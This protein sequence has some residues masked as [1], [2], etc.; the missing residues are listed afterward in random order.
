MSQY[1]SKSEFDL[2]KRVHLTNEIP[3]FDM[4]DAVNSVLQDNNLWKW[5]LGS[6]VVD[7]N[8][9]YAVNV[10][11]ENT[12]TVSKKRFLE[13]GEVYYKM[14]NG[15]IADNYGPI[16]NPE[17]VYHKLEVYGVLMPEFDFLL[18]EVYRYLDSEYPDHPDYKELL[19]DNEFND[20]INAAGE[21]IDYVPDNSFFK[22]VASSLKDL[23]TDDIDTESIMIKIRNL[24]NEAFR[25]KLYGSK[26]GYKM[27]AS[28]IYQNATVFPVATYLPLKPI[29]KEKI[30][31]EFDY[32]SE[33]KTPFNNKDLLK[34]WNE[35]KGFDY[36]QEQYK[37]YIR[38]YERN[39][40]TYNKNYYKKFRLIDIDGSNSSYP[41]PKDNNNYVFG[42]SIPFHNNT[43]FELPPCSDIESKISLLK[44][45][46]VFNYDKDS[47]TRYISNINADIPYTS[48]EY[49]D[50]S[51]S[52][53]EIKNI[54]SEVHSFD[55]TYKVQ[56][57][58]QKVFLYHRIDEDMVSQFEDKLYVGYSYISNDTNRDIKEETSSFITE[59]YGLNNLGNEGIKKYISN[60]D[61][62]YSPLIENA[63]YLKPSKTVERYAKDIP[64]D[65]DEYKEDIYEPETVWDYSDNGVHKGAFLSRTLVASDKSKIVYDSHEITNF[66]RGFID[67]TIDAITANKNLQFKSYNESLDLKG[68]SKNRYGIVL[69][70]SE[71]NLVVMYGKLELFEDIIGIQYKLKRIKFY[72]SAIPNEKNDSVL[73]SCYPE[74]FRLREEMNSFKGL[75]DASIENNNYNLST[76][77]KYLYGNADIQNLAEKEIKE[78]GLDY[79]EFLEWAKSYFD[80]KIQLDSM[81]ENR[82]YIYKNIDSETE[83]SLLYPGLKVVGFLEG[84]TPLNTFDLSNIETYNNIDFL[85]HGRVS[86]ITL[87]NLN[88]T[89][90]YSNSIADDYVE[91]KVIPIKDKYLCYLG[92]KDNYSNHNT[93]E[94][95]TKIGN[96]E[97]FY[98]YFTQTPSKL[99]DGF[100]NGISNSPDV[101][102]YLYTVTFSDTSEVKIESFIDVS[103]EG[104]EN[105]IFFKSDLSKELYKTLSVGDIIIGPG[106]DSDDEDVYITSIGDNFVTTS[107]NLISSGTFVLTYLVKMNITTKDLTD[108]I[109][110]YKSEL[111]KNKLYSVTN[112]FEHGL[113]PSNDWPRVSNAILDSIPDM[114]FYKVDNRS[115]NGTYNLTT[116]M[117]AIYND[118]DEEFN[119]STEKLL[120][121][122]DIKFNN[123]LFYE[124]NLNK[125]LQ[126][127]DK[128]GVSPILMS[129]DWLDYL[130][131][132]LPRIT[133]ATD[134][135]NVGVNLMME[136]D[137][138]GYYT[139]CNN[140]NYTDPYINLRFITL[141]LQYKNA[142]NESS[143]SSKDWTVPV[144]AQVGTG[145]SSRKRWFRTPSDISYPAIWGNS[146]YNKEIDGAKINEDS[147][148][149]KENGELKTVYVWGGKDVIEQKSGRESVFSSVEAPLFEIPL[150][151]Y[152]TVIKNVDSLHNNNLTTI[153]QASFYA[154]T[155]TD[156]M[157]AFTAED[158]V[159]KINANNISDSNLLL[160][161]PNFNQ[162]IQTFNKGSLDGIVVSTD[163]TNFIYK[164]YWN[165]EKVLI[166]NTDGVDYY[167]VNYPTVDTSDTVY[168]I[169]SK[170]C[171]LT[172]I[173][174]KHEDIDFSKNSL[175]F[176]YKNKW[177]IKNYQYVSVVGELNT[178]FN[179]ELVKLLPDSNKAPNDDYPLF[180]RLLHYYI[181]TSGRISNSETTGIFNTSYLEEIEKAETNNFS[182]YYN[183]L[184][185]EN[186]ILPE[187][188]LV[189][190][191]YSD[192]YD[193]YIGYSMIFMYIGDS[194]ES[195]SKDYYNYL[196]NKGLSEFINQGTRLFLTCFGTTDEEKERLEEK[197]IDVPS[198]DWFIYKINT[199]NFLGASI[200]ISR[201]KSQTDVEYGIAVGDYDSNFNDGKGIGYMVEV[202]KFNSTF[203]LPRK[204]I[205]EGSYN[206]DFIIDPQF[207]SV[208][209]L[210]TDDYT[211]DTNNEVTFCIT[212][213]NIYYDDL[214]QSFFTYA[215]IINETLDSNYIKKNVINDK[216]LKK[217]S[218]KFN[219]QKFFKNVLNTACSYQIK[220]GLTVGENTIKEIPT[221]NTIVGINFDVDHLKVGDRI[222]EVNEIILRSLYS[223]ALEPTLFSNYVDM[224]FNI[225]GVTKN[226]ELYLGLGKYNSINTNKDDFKNFIPVIKDDSTEDGFLQFDTENDVITFNK[227]YDTSLGVQRFL[228]PTVVD[229]KVKKSYLDDTYSGKPYM[230][231]EF[232]YFKNNLVFKGLVNSRYSN[233]IQIPNDDKSLFN[234]ALN[235]LNVGDTLK[236]GIYL[237]GSAFMSNTKVDLTYKGNPLITAQRPDIDPSELA[238]ISPRVGLR[239]I[240]F[241]NGEL[242]AVFDSNPE[243]EIIELYYKLDVDLVAIGSVIDFDYYVTIKRTT[244]RGTIQDLSYDSDNYCWIINIGDES[245]SNL[246]RIPSLEQLAGMVEPGVAYEC[247][248]LFQNYRVMYVNNTATEETKVFGS[249]YKVLTSS[250]MPEVSEESIIQDAESYVKLNNSVIIGVDNEQGV[251]EDGDSIIKVDNVFYKD[252]AVLSGEFKADFDNPIQITDIETDT[253]K[254]GYLFEIKELTRADNSPYFTRSYC[255]TDTATGGVQ[256]LGLDIDTKS[257]YAESYNGIYAAYAKGRDLFIKSPT[258]LVD[259]NITTSSYEYNGRNSIKSFWK[260]TKAPVLRDKNLLELKSIVSMDTNKAYENLKKDAKSFLEYFTEFKNAIT[261]SRDVSSY[262]D[263]MERFFIG[264]EKV[265]KLSE[266]TVSQTDFT[267]IYNIIN[268]YCSENNVIS[269]DSFK[270][271]VLE[272]RKTK[273]TQKLLNNNIIIEYKVSNILVTFK[274]FTI[275][276]TLVTDDDLTTVG[277]DYKTCIKFGN[278]EKTTYKVINNAKLDF[279][280]L[281]VY[282]VYY[283]YFFMMGSSPFNDVT[284]S[285]GIEKMI[286]TNEYLFVIDKRGITSKIGLGSLTKTVDIENPNNWVTA[287][288]PDNYYFKGVDTNLYSES[289]IEL[290]DG[291]ILTQRQSD[292]LINIPIFKPTCNYITGNTVIIGGYLESKAV[293]EDMYKSGRSRDG[294]ELSDDDKE[295]LKGLKAKSWFDDRTCPAVIYSNDNGATFEILKLENI[296]NTKSDEFNHKITSIRY[297]N[298]EYLFYTEGTNNVPSKNKIYYIPKNT[299]G[300]FDFSIGA[301]ARD[302]SVEE[303]NLGTCEEFDVDASRNLNTTYVAEGLIEE[304]TP[305]VAS[306]EG[307]Y[308]FYITP[309]AEYFYIAGLGMLNT[310]NH[311]V[312]DKTETT[313]TLSS[314]LLL[315]TKKG[316]FTVLLS[317]YTE[318]DIPDQRL[319]LNEK[320]VNTDSVISYVNKKG[321]LRVPEVTEVFSKDK[322]NRFY[323]YRE[324]IKNSY[325]N[326]SYGYPT[327]EEDYNN[328]LYNYSTVNQLIDGEYKEVL[329]ADIMVNS[330]GNPVYLCD[331]TG[332]SLLSVN[333]DFTPEYNEDEMPPNYYFRY[334]YLRRGNLDT[335]LLVKAKDVKY[336]SVSE[337]DSKS[338]LLMN[339]TDFED[340]IGSDATITEFNYASDS[341]YM[342]YKPNND[343]LLNLALL[344][345]T[346]LFKYGAPVYDDEDETVVSLKEYAEDNMELISY[347]ENSN[348]D[349]VPGKNPNRIEELK[350]TKDG[351]EIPRF[352]GVQVYNDEEGNPVYFWYDNLME[353][354]PLKHIRTLFGQAKLEYSHVGGLYHYKYPN[355]QSIGTDENKYPHPV[356]GIFLHNLGYGGSRNNTD[357]WKY[358]L[359]WQID[360]KAFTDDYL[361]NTKGDYVYLTDGLGNVIISNSSETESIT[362]ENFTITKNSFGDK[363][364]KDVIV[365]TKDLSKS[366]KFYRT[367]ENTNT[368]YKAYNEIQLSGKQD[369]YMSLFLI[370]NGY[371]LPFDDVSI[372]LYGINEENIYTKVDSDLGTQDNHKGFYYDKE[373]LELRFA[374]LEDFLNPIDFGLKGIDSLKLECTYKDFTC[375]ET[376]PLRIDTSDNLN[377]VTPSIKVSNI[378]GFIKNTDNNYKYFGYNIYNNLDYLPLISVSIDTEMYDDT[379][380]LGLYNNQYYQ[381]SNSLIKLNYENNDSSRKKFDASFIPNEN[382]FSNVQCSNILITNNYT[383]FEI[384]C[385]ISTIGEIKV[386]P[387]SYY[388][389][390]DIISKEQL[391][392]NSDVIEHSDFIGSLEEDSV[393][394]Y[395]LNKGNDV[396]LEL[397]K[398]TDLESGI[399]K[400]FVIKSDKSIVM[401]SD[402]DITFSI[403]YKENDVFIKKDIIISGI[404]GKVICK[405]PKYESFNRLINNEGLIIDGKNLLKYNG[406]NLTN[407]SYIDKNEGL[408]QL[409]DPLRIDTL[410]DG[411]EHYLKIKVLTQ[412]TILPD[413]STVNND[414]TYVEISLTDKELFTP[415]RVWFN[416]KGYPIPTVTI[417]NTV[418]GSESNSNYYDNTYLNNNNMSI[419]R[420][421]EEGKIIGY[422]L[423]DSSKVG[424]LNADDFDYCLKDSLGNVTFAAKEVVIDK[425]MSL[426]IAQIPNEPIYKS[427]QEWFKDSFYIKGQESNPFWQVLNITSKYDSIKKSWNQTYN[428]YEY[429]KSSLSIIKNNLSKDES[430]INIT[431]TDFYTVTDNGIITDPDEKYVDIKNGIIKFIISKPQDLYK[432]TKTF[433]KYGITANNSFYDSETNPSLYKG[434]WSGQDVTLPGFI[435]ST[436]TVNSTQNLANKNEKDSEIQSV[437]ELGLFNKYHQLIAYAVFPPIEY[438]TSSQHISFTCYVKQGG[439]S[440]IHNE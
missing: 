97:H 65:S 136:T 249:A 74:Y 354:F 94:Y 402:D 286:F 384:N 232:K 367:R 297:S 268:R 71:G 18:H 129:V 345:N 275:K 387:S 364:E 212:C 322:A 141:N 234:D 247:P 378:L 45:N 195:T 217:V 192:V 224:N 113:W 320:Y 412:S 373:N 161:I 396:L 39:I 358:K 277:A 368:L 88:V 257:V 226:E 102:D 321:N 348:E 32:S 183:L 246:I 29:T 51:K 425:T 315:N 36:D 139:L 433:I 38:K 101:N 307:I 115:F 13:S 178:K 220:R 202:D 145:G 294:D 222:L 20:L 404:V 182:D 47:I 60:I 16:H 177:F 103:V 104:Q 405:R 70:N 376:I 362:G 81:K 64:F 334:L 325:I 204:Y 256:P 93:Y 290:S 349:N 75:L 329:Q 125:L 403:L 390:T 173:S 92:V 401:D 385:P 21:I 420:C 133:R 138:T 304:A 281:Y 52:L 231:R 209:Y 253:Q 241:Y 265:T 300:V 361:V 85:L 218:I 109:N 346:P 355:L 15:V 318:E 423:L 199:N 326:D 219:E 228:K 100:K 370:R 87:G 62:L 134:N 98:D 258:A 254:E 148:F 440:D 162:S 422:Q 19:T 240:K 67:V 11:D 397:N 1:T 328:V 4:Y 303:A 271:A 359:P 33:G 419:Y 227:D 366:F 369:F 121:P 400:S 282:Y 157:K 193:A 407:I 203:D 194:K 408:I 211:I 399:E 437:T 146:I 124:L 264:G 167:K 285:S 259:Y 244:S 56:P 306:P 117:D 424:K 197:G 273:S 207:T 55:V 168:Y 213:G 10:L 205:T 284:I 91:T 430:F 372:S 288:L 152:D 114:S 181:R 50:T 89:R 279:E 266:K 344:E 54:D 236:G 383:T 242:L 108:D 176:Y 410:N 435:K 398:I 316:E 118:T 166:K 30:N 200:P 233:I 191:K 352:T 160:P 40:D 339:D 135:V 434:I 86:D 34:E 7:F 163:I 112:P 44:V 105:I 229:P 78:S 208:G 198:R 171:K 365:T 142:W 439:L 159:I 438:R 26:Y 72:I 131:N 392:I 394:K 140:Q 377:Y 418:F 128:K 43:I 79:T 395:F 49:D 77:E 137:T 360:P 149:Y 37:D 28:D 95:V 252:Y 147:D 245:G 154:Q 96:T 301:P 123:E 340:V 347:L 429:K 274:G 17:E 185:R 235:V 42:Y 5:V 151:E 333:P 82:S 255:S 292:T 414:D 156:L 302:I 169:I 6:T 250:L 188:N 411:E 180:D 111:Y 289:Y 287:V 323:S 317:F 393:K 338:E 308:R 61:V 122:S 280:N 406:D 278:D 130:D 53:L 27:F 187:E 69:E 295:F 58:Y 311:I 120:L 299:A 391:F 267:T 386:L 196:Y 324:L 436:Y 214:N 341:S 116:I 9:P 76:A 332:N 14:V 8:L 110:Y 175:L 413:I 382:I 164:G 216:G 190:N 165:P 283:L 305:Y 427:C 186:R 388:N 269:Y 272:C 319:Y 221:L 415:D 174:K 225:L 374:K 379:Y 201:Y 350:I 312:I 90:H 260:H 353:M 223:N 263:I 119:S 409:S 251:N 155:F 351:Q 291:R 313:V 293:I 184:F 158:N 262:S 143:I 172:D 22:K 421:N 337:L 2:E 210:Y 41:E 381:S 357:M 363:Y 83:E 35:T 189:G 270:Q 57:L 48:I 276:E 3:P 375:S 106:I 342:I 428:I 68:V 12:G 179:E 416:T 107:K 150:G 84:V 206:F 126:Y 24:R 356:T 335:E 310:Q 417:G 66:T 63:V 153:T 230:D 431:P 298:N 380:V 296:F 426:D 261:G 309:D 330:K 144:Y 25:R 46:S 331:Y 248:T 127:S 238:E 59:I 327:E 23:T 314:N 132:N 215:N 170:D 336:E 432:S 343:I 80:I 99:T 73:L 243:S 389:G 371:M 237:D 239:K 31:S